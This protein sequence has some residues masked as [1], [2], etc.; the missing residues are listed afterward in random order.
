MQHI[1]S[2][3]S[4]VYCFGHVQNGVP[5]LSVHVPPFLQGFGLQLS[6]ADRQNEK[7]HQSHHCYHLGAVLT[8]QTVLAFIS[9]S[10]LKVLANHMTSDASPT[11]IELKI[12]TSLLSVIFAILIRGHSER[13]KNHLKT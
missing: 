6:V 2:H 12:F 9:R 1:P 4:P 8:D 11:W 3:L 7:F 5:S 13:W 10:V